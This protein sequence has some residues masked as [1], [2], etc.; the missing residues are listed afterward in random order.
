MCFISFVVGEEWGY[1]E[2]RGEAIQASV[3]VVEF[4]RLLVEWLRDYVP[5]WLRTFT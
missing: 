5:T 4:K 1:I 2:R 3:L